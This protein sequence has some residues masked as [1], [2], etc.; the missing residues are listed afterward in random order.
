MAKQPIVVTLLAG[1][2]GDGLKTAQK[3]LQGLGDTV[4]RL[5]TSALKAGAGLALA[6]GWQTFTSVTGDAITQ[7]RDLE[8]NLAAVDTVFG[9]LA[10]KITEFSQGAYQMGLSQSEAAKA[11]VFLGSV[12][13]QSGFSIE[14]T[15]DQ[16]ERLLTL[17]ADL[18]LTYGYDVQEALLGMTALFR[19]EY[20]PI[21]KFGV[22]MKQSE[23]NSELA[24]KGLNHLEGAERRLAEQQIRLN[25]LFERATDAQG[26]F[27]RQSGTLAVEQER[28]QASINNMLQ[29]AGT[30]LL[31]VIA[32]LAETMVPVVEDLT[33]T[34]TAVFED[35]AGKAKVLLSDTEGLK[36]AIKETAV[37][38]GEIIKA[39]NS[40]ALFIGQN[41]VAISR[42]VVALVAFKA[43]SKVGY[44][45]AA[46]ME[47]YKA[48]AVAATAA[49]ASL[50]ATLKA[51]IF[52]AIAAGIALLIP[53]MGDYVD[54][55]KKG[56]EAE[57]AIDSE[58][59]IRIDRIK[60]LKAQEEDL[61][62][63]MGGVSGYIADTYVPEL[64]KV[65]DELARLEA[66]AKNTN[67][68]VAG[69]TASGMSHLREL[70]TSITPYVELNLDGDGGD[71]GNGTAQEIKDY[72]GDFYAALEDEIAKQAARVRLQTMGATEGL[73]SSILSGEGWEEVFA[74]IV[75]KGIS[76]VARLQE[77]FNTTAAGIKELADALQTELDRIDKEYEL[78][79]ENQKTAIADLESAYAA[80]AD[81][82]TSTGEAFEDFFET[83]SI[84]PTTEREIGRFE[85]QAIGSLESIESQLKG[86]LRAL[87]EDFRASYNYL[88]D[89]ARR[90]L[91]KLAEI[92]RERDEFAKRRSLAEALI[93]DVKA[94]TVGAANITSI[95][96]KAQA[97]VD[98]VK[99]TDVIAET[100]EAGRDL[101]EFRVTIMR[102]VVEPMATAGSVIDGFR[103]IVAKTRVFIQ[104][105]KTLRELGLDPQLFSQLV[106][107]GVEAG[108]ETAQALVDGGS[109][110]ITELNG[111]FGE[112]NTLGAELGEETAQVMY[113]AG[114]DLT[115]GIIEGIAAEQAALEEQASILASAF[116]LV[117]S[118][119]LEAAMDNALRV[120]NERIEA[121]KAEL[122]R[123]L[124]EMEAAKNKVKEDYP[125]DAGGTAPTAPVEA[126]VEAIEEVAEVV[127]DVGD[128]IKETTETVEE[129]TKATAEAVKT[130]KQT[131]FESAGMRH[132]AEL[133]NQFTP[134]IKDTSGISQAGMSH[135]ASLQSMSTRPTFTINVNA[136]GRTQGTQA[137][138]AIVSS[139]KKYGAVNGGSSLKFSVL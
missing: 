123:I 71:G 107:A 43:A 37:A 8:R 51:N 29:E 105:L 89:Y 113:G 48:K 53:L 95:F 99:A 54:R 94:A 66:Q 97:A 9:G 18:A 132:V 7:A 50:N 126:I 101:K 77:A 4:N 21:E 124:D 129:S 60:E 45:A 80:A 23:I 137:G 46:A 2:K 106:E 19:G 82:V 128:T 109:D 115:N 104:N 76:E 6:K 41:A 88:V 96:S 64:K 32:E 22:A 20:D 10:P 83:F 122:Q 61:V 3:Q 102:D 40:M 67:N 117:F 33:P 112:L 111:L 44:L 30:P 14:E 118:T 1:F 85:Q 68:A 87:G 27:E 42:L 31:G 127:K 110:S 134:R 38:M 133:T 100:I 121:A 25:L 16:T 131:G 103:D 108:G 63:K 28:L 15:A 55:L 93:G 138:E 36:E 120:I 35:L 17:G 92:Q 79:I 139:L 11:S 65:R 39:A 86:T 26:A 34:M 72:V 136:N 52:G 91:T 119:Q 69:F 81:T 49:T 90:E 47:V 116:E 78:E 75:D 57:R 24:A 114:I 74:S 70:Q 62:A 56:V 73:I 13:K 130:V 58:Q 98:K 135:L 12:L 84:L 125:I 5:S 59:R